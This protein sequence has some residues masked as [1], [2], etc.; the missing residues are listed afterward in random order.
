MR[1]WEGSSPSDTLSSVIHPSNSSLSQQCL[2]L[3]SREGG[4]STV[5]LGLLHT[6]ELR[7]NHRGLQMSS[8]FF[9]MGP[10]KI[11]M[12]FVSS[13]ADWDPR[14]LR[15]RNWLPAPLSI[16]HLHN[17]DLI[18]T[19]Y[20]GVQQTVWNSCVRLREEAS[21]C[22]SLACVTVSQD[23]CYFFKPIYSVSAL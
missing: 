23:G 18:S 13:G 2:S 17:L 11:T 15:R 6:L 16:H 3:T 19:N 8:G 10:L 21:T 7:T 22:Q 9:F 5:I 4:L 20:S 1:S 14:W 12:Q